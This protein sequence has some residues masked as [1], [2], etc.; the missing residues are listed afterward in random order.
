MV[1]PLSYFSFQPVLHDQYNKGCG[2]CYPVWDGAYKITLAANHKVANIVAEV[3]F[4]S[5][6]LNVTICLTPYNKD[7]YMHHLRQDSTHNDPCHTVP[8]GAPVGTRNSLA[9][10]P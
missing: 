5:H 8:C 7:C 2:I 10:P 6:Y 1:D 3:G 9:C 4:L